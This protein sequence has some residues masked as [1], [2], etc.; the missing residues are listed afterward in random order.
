LALVG[1]AGEQKAAKNLGQTKGHKMHGD[2]R[3]FRPTYTDKKTGKKRTVST[4][5]IQYSVGGKKYVESTGSAN[6]Q[7]A[8]DLKR[9]RIGDRK[10]GRII[11]RPDRITLHELREGLE[12]YY[13]RQGNRSLDRAKAA[14]DNIEEFFKEGCRALAISRGRVAE[15]VDKRLKTDKRAPATVRYE[16][17]MLNLAFNIAVQEDKLAVPPQFKGP[18]VNNIRGQFFTAEEFALVLLHLIPEMHALANFLYWVPWRRNDAINLRWIAC[19]WETKELRLTPQTTK[20][21]KGR[22]F[23]FGQAPEVEVLLNKMWKR[24]TS[25]DGFVFHDGTG[26][27][28]GISFVRYN[29]NKAVTC[30]GMKGRVLHSLRAS[31]IRNY[32]LAGVTEADTMRLSGHRTRATF[33]RYNLANVEDGQRAVAARFAKKEPKLESS[34]KGTEKD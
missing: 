17:A 8:L 5:Y 34:S 32:R 3:I 18:A 28:L 2:G 33:E 7:V 9:A 14:F 1:N 26:K 11:N 4:W 23:P 29:W 13:E 19:D 22:V 16:I 10:A 15:Y 20:E 27:P 6:R 21:K 31:S 24:R 30:G 25:D 12:R